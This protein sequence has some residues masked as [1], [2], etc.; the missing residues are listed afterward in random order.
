MIFM[1]ELQPR[2][3]LGCMAKKHATHK[4]MNR[5]HQYSRI[6]FTDKKQPEDVKKI[7]SSGLFQF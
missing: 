6:I 3:T 5:N 1:A 4:K 2:L 7:A